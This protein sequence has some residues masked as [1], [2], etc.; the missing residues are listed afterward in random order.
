[1]AKLKKSTTVTGGL[2]FNVIKE[3]E[4]ESDTIQQQS[5]NKKSIDSNVRGIRKSSSQDKNNQN[6][7]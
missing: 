5:N 6:A 1:M 2:G 4:N 7:K 3:S